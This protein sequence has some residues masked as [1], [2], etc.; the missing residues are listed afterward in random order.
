M[1]KYMVVFAVAGILTM[2]AANKSNPTSGSWQVD[3]GH[4]DAQ[5]ITDATTD[6]G[7]QKIDATLGFARVNGKMILDGDPTKSSVDLVIYPAT[8]MSP[9][10]DED[11]KFQ[12]QWLANRANH[13]LICFHSKNIARTGDSRLQTTGNLVLTRVDR[14][15]IEANA[16]EAYSGPVYGPPIIHRVSREATFVFELPATTGNREKDG[17]FGVSGSTSMF[18]EGFPQLLGTVI[19]T[20]W[21]PVVQDENCQNTGPIESYQGPRCTGMVL[22]APGLPA[23]PHAGNLEDYPGP[24][25]FNA[26]VGNHLTILVHM[27]LTPKAPGEQ[28]AAGN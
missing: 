8:S 21:P 5:L 20:N 14:N 24:S 26:I 2:G 9:P 27:R 28:P 15:V 12:S 13:T 25:G 7:K 16:N 10:I 17:G 3:T 4:S 22:K 11:G 18:R 6:Y 1:F 23:A 19:S